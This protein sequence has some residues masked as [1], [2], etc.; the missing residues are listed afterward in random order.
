TKFVL[1]QAELETDAN[2]KPVRMRGT[3]F[4]TTA[5]NRA[6]EDLRAARNRAECAN[7]AKSQFLANMS[8]ELR[9]PL[10]AIIGFSELMAG[11]LLG[12]TTDGQYKSY[13]KDINDSGYHL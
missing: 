11:D 8:H 3:V 4:D 13:A 7:R 5:I 2:G 6:T 9:T 10:N 12:P 1:E